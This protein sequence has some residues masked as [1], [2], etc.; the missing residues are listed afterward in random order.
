MTRRI[1]LW[2]TIIVPACVFAVVLIVASP[3]SSEQ[4]RPGGGVKKRSAKA[5]VDYTGATS[6]LDLGDSIPVWGYDTLGFI[7]TVRMT[8]GKLDINAK[9]DSGARSS[10]VD[11]RDIVPFERDGKPWV[12]FT[13]IGDNGRSFRTE[14]PVQRI[15]RI[16]RASGEAQRRYVVLL[17]LCVGSYYKLAEVNLV[18]RGHLR[19]RMIIGRHFMMDQFLID[20]ASLF[21]TE[22]SC[23]KEF[24]ASAR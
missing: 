5:Y 23:T 15:A 11:A 20:P 8:P 13:L 18:Y 10:S 24:A 22:P 9:I 12:R 1:S 7:E 17:G 4:K 2:T 14:Q 16:R 3:A 19:Y 6:R 21:L